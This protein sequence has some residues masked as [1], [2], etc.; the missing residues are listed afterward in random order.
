MIT[1]HACSKDSST[2]ITNSYNPKT[3]D[4]FDNNVSSFIEYANDHLGSKRFYLE[5]DTFDA[6]DEQEEWVEDENS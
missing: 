6:T 4:E 5:F 3:K 1:I 2:V